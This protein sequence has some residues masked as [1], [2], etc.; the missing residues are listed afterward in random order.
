MTLDGGQIMGLYQERWKVE[1]YHK[2][3]KQNASLSCSPTRTKRT[4][5]NHFFL[6]LCAFVKLET[7]KVKTKCGHFA[8]KQKLY[9]AALQAAFDQLQTLQPDNLRRSA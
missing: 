4:Q 3:L 2:S 5:S 9:V 1:E 7:L 6:S 8:L